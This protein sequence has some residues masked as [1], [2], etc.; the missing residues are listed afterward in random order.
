MELQQVSIPRS[1]FPKE[2][3]LQ[4]ILL[5]IFSDDTERAYVNL[6]YI[7]ATDTKAITHISLVFDKTKVAP[8]NRRN[9]PQLELCGALI[10]ALLLKHTSM[11]LSIP[12]GKTEV[13]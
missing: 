2:A 10:I 12:R 8:S 13:N 3:N 6:V 5:H 4:E 1:Y 7:R 11:V 9:V